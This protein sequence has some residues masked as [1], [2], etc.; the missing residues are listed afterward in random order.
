MDVP[1]TNRWTVEEQAQC[2]QTHPDS[3]MLLELHRNKK[4]L[5][6]YFLLGQGD[7]LINRVPP[8]PE[9]S[10]NKQMETVTDKLGGAVLRKKKQR[11]LQVHIHLHVHG[12]M[13]TQ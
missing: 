4:N 7:S 2:L 11:I 13:E 6:K 5:Q 12:N 9:P 8:S 3:A 10:I 1:D